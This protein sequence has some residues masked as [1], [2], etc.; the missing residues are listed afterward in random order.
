MLST[1]VNAGGKTLD[2]GKT[3][4]GDESNVKGDGAWFAGGRLAGS[5]GGKS[6]HGDR[7]SGTASVH[8]GASNGANDRAGDVGVRGGGLG[9]GLT[10]HC[11]GCWYVLDFRSRER[12]RGE[13]L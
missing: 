9:W 4:R 8:G 10:I 11:Q 13:T 3:A 6:M 12:T 2:A 5:E 1:R 7:S